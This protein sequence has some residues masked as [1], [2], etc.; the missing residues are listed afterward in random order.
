MFSCGPKVVKGIPVV[1]VQD[2]LKSSIVGNDDEALTNR[3]EM[4]EQQMDSI[5][6]SRTLNNAEVVA[7]QMLYT[8]KTFR[9][10]D[11]IIDSLFHVKTTISRSAFFSPDFEHVIIK[12]EAPNNVLIDI[13][14]IQNQKLTSVLKHDQWALTYVS[15]TLKD[16][17]GDGY[18]D[19][20]LNWYG[21]NGCCL[22]GFSDVYLY[23]PK[24]GTFTDQFEFINP[25]FLP[26]EKVIRGVCYGH[27]GET[28]MYTYKWKGEA[29]DTI[30][31]ISY[32]KKDNGE[33]TGKFISCKKARQGIKDIKRLNAM[34]EEYKSIEGYDWFTGDGFE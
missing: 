22:K 12:R 10:F 28:E 29:I 19:Y 31:Y 6:L 11:Q 25:T 18:K 8:G 17:N 9:E 5:R 32:E 30:E 4:G 27:P 34:P 23:Q 33:K 14:V 16:I 26:K 3:G 13:Y 21:S 7:Q 2:T 24:T 1:S 20:V 15:D